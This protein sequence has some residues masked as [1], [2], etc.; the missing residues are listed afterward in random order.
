MAFFEFVAELFIRVVW[1][2]LMNFI[3]ACI[4]FL[5]VK[6]KFKELMED[7]ISPLIGVVFVTIAIVLIL[8]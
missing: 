8:K 5:F 6:K 2:G 4:R 3:G 1:E 7:R